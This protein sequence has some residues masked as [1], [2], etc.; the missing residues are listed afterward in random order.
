MFPYGVF[1]SL[2]V[3]DFLCAPLHGML[4]TIPQSLQHPKT[5]HSHHH[6]CSLHHLCSSYTC[7]SI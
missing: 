2:A 4:L 3:P 5:H 6:G 1:F 7:G